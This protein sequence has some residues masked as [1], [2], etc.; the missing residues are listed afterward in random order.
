MS[1]TV[2]SQ[3]VTVEVILPKI[4]LFETGLSRQEASAALLRAFILSLYRQDRISTGKAARLLGIER[5]AFIR[6]LAE[7][8]IPY[9]DYTTEELT[10]EIAALDQWLPH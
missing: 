6:I 2:S 8:E 1:N 3:N 7:E 5:L 4:L 9:L 10:T